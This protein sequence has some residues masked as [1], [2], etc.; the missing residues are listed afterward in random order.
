M[1][2]GDL[3]LRISF[4]NFRDKSEADLGTFNAN[5][6]LNQPVLITWKWHQG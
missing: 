1:C 6:Q 4:K 3:K 5:V 2:L